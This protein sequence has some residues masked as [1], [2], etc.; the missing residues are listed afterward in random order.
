V[1]TTFTLSEGEG[2]ET[3]EDEDTD[4]DE[5]GLTDKEEVDLGTDPNNEDSDGD[6][7]RD[8]AEV[9]AGTDPNDVDDYLAD[10]EDFYID[11]NDPFTD[12]AG[13]FAEKAICILYDEGV[14]Q[15]RSSTHYEPSSSITRAE[16]LKIA[17]LNAGLTVTADTSVEYDD[18]D[19]SDWYY[20]YITYATSEGYV[21]GYGDGTFMPND[22][23]NRAEAMIMLMRIAGVEEADVDTSDT[24]FDDV[25]SDDWFAWAVV[26][27]ADNG[28]SEGYSDDTFKPGNSITRAEVAVLARRMWYVYFE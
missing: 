27:A 8:G 12:T 19:S 6:G 23:I 10:G 1:S 28:I 15:G 24:S 4:T 16:F 26:E 11:C 21:E 25:D 22:E 7:I 2:V 5:D 17:L 3:E 14:V 18:V 9:A 20:S 13:N